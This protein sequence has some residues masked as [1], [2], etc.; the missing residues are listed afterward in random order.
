MVRAVRGGNVGWLDIWRHEAVNFVSSHVN[1]QNISKISHTVS[2]L[3][4]SLPRVSCTSS[5]VLR[6]SSCELWNNPLNTETSGLVGAPQQKE[7]NSPTSSGPIHEPVSIYRGKLILFVS[8]ELNG[9]TD[10][11]KNIKCFNSVYVIQFYNRIRHANTFKS[12]TLI[13][14]RTHVDILTPPANL[15]PLRA[16]PQPP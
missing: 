13:V 7:N 2:S 10:V 15:D 4:K 8:L 16:W 6:R 3:C 12:W 14:V 5:S 11:A 9:K 1:R